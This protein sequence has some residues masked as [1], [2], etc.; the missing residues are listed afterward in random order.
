MKP[1]YRLI[2]SRFALNKW[3]VFIVS[4]DGDILDYDGYFIKKIAIIP[5][6]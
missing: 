6:L 1:R 5:M 2:R 3:D 4:K